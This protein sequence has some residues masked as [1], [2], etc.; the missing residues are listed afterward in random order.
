MADRTAFY[1]AATAAGMRPEDV[2][3]AVE[4]A[5]HLDNDLLMRPV[6]GLWRPVV[7]FS[8]VRLSLRPNGTVIGT[9]ESM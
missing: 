2:N 4:L 7:F 5:E 3:R 8:P 1:F 9:G 6:E